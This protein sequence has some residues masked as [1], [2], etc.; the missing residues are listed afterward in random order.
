MH[1]KFHLRIFFNNKSQND[2][3]IKFVRFIYDSLFYTL[4][5]FFIASISFGQSKQVLL[6]EA[7]YYFSRQDF[8]AASHFFELAYQ[9]DSGDVQQWWK[10]AEAYRFTF[11]YDL[12]AQFYRKVYQKDRALNYPNV[13]LWEGVMHKQSDD[14]EGAIKTLQSYLE[15]QLNPFQ[16]LLSKRTD[17]AGKELILQLVCKTQ[18][19]LCSI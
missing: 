17:G 8:Y 9:K 18:K 7:D 12:A 13:Q 4:L 10:M 19:R 5:F 11:Q 2:R 16:F 14:Y 1:G 6:R 15:N 3:V